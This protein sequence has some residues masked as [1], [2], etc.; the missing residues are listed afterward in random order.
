MSQLIR[1][2]RA[3]SHF[4]DSNYRNKFLTAKLLKQGYRYH[5]LRKAFSN[6]IVG[7]LNGSKNVMSMLHGISNAEL[8]GDLVYKKIII[9]NPNFSDLFK[10]DVN[11]FKRAGYTLEIMRQTACLVFNIFMVEAYAALFSCTAVVQA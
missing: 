8:Y 3:S 9:G 7:T 2:A 10:R 5:K 4:S 1:F 11:R 6:F